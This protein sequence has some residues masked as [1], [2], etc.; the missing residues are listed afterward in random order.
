MVVYPIISFKEII[1][2]NYDMNEEKEYVTKQINLL[3]ENLNNITFQFLKNPDSDWRNDIE[4]EIKK[5]L[6]EINYNLIHEELA[7]RNDIKYIRIENYKDY[8][9]TH[10]VAYEMAIRNDKVIKLTNL[11]EELNIL[12]LYI[13]SNVSIDKKMELFTTC[14]NLKHENENE[15]AIE[16]NNN[17]SNNLINKIKQIG[18]SIDSMTVDSLTQINITSIN[19]SFDNIINKYSD[20]YLF[21][22]INEYYEENLNPYLKQYQE[23]TLQK[24][25]DKASNQDKVN[26]INLLSKSVQTKLEKEYYLVNEYNSIKPEYLE[27]FIPKDTNH[28]PNAEIDKHINIINRNSNYT[29]NYIYEKGYTSYQGAFKDD[30][31][32]Y[33]NKV[34]PNFS[35]PLRMFNTMEISINPSLPLNDILSFVKKIKEDYD[36]KESFKSFFEL[37]M[38]DLIIPSNMKDTVDKL[39][40]YNKRKWA[41]MFYIYDYFQFHLSENNQINKGK[42]IK[43]K[44]KKEEKETTIAK[45]ISLQLSYYHILGDK[46]PLDFSESSDIGEY[47]SAYDKYQTDFFFKIEDNKEY[48]K[49]IKFKKDKDG[50]EE[51]IVKFYMSADHIKTDYYPKMKKLIEGNNPEYIKFV[52]GRNHDLDSFIDGKNN[53]STKL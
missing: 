3:T 14:Q 6:K 49:Y 23:N 38:K 18:Y 25:V 4:N 41:D 50:I 39:T 12:T 31:S 33:I 19:A 48:S 29:E 15:N 24:L 28:E 35:Q 22:I 36:N 17:S 43:D 44:K 52:N 21:N 47:N 51:K 30:N 32:F 34:I 7:E 45:E 20:N 27:E 37:A 46:T 26:L 10:C 9:F 5:T 40:S 16:V 13:L 8:E 1:L 11:L 2:K 53:A 42:T